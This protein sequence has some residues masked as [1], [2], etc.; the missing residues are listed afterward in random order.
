MTH[1]DDKGTVQLLED[2]ITWDGFTMRGV[3][4]EENGEANGPGMYTSPASSGYSILNT[5]FEDNGI[6]LHLGSD[7]AHPTVVCGNL[8]TANNEF[9]G[10]G[11]ATGIY[12]NEGAGKVLITSNRFERHNT[13]AIFFADIDEDPATPHVLQQDILIEGNTSVDDLS[14]AVIYNSSWVRLTGNDIRA[15]VGDEHFSGPASAIRI[16]AR[17]HDVVVDRNRIRSAIGNG[18]DVTDSGDLRREASAPTGVLV[19][20][21]KVQHAELFGIDVS[22]SGVREYEV[23]D[24]CVLANG[25][26]GIHLGPRSDDARITGNTALG[27]GGADGFDCQDESKGESATDGTAGTENTWQENVGATADPR[28]ICGPPADDDQPTGDGKHHGK[29]HHGQ[30]HKQH[31]GHKEHKTHRQDPCGCIRLSWRF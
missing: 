21:N 3:P 22:A 27:N 24:N 15:R 5:V 10:A 29:Q 26:V 9:E 8:F 28:A 4:H 2:D 23:R 30:P 13:S 17:S 16:G 14:F 20:K 31:K 1:R 11:G 19:L 7:G 25:E 6:G 18:I 12:S